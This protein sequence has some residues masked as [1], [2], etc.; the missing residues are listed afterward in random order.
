MDC[1]ATQ[2]YSIVS[3]LHLDNGLHRH[4]VL[5]THH[6]PCPLSTW[7]MD[8]TVTQYY[9]LTTVH[10]LSSTWTMDITVTQCY[11]PVSSRP[12]GQWIL[13]SHSVT[14]LCPLVHLDNGYY[15][16]TVLL[17]CV[18]SST[19]TMDI[20]VTQCYSP[21]SSRPPGQ[22]ISPS[23][24]T[25]YSPQFISSRPPGQWI[26]PSHSVTHLC[27]PVHLDNGYHRHTV[28]YTHHSSFPLVHLDNG[29]HR[30]TVPYTHH[31]SFPL[32][33]LDNGYHRHTVLYTHY[34]S[35]P[36]VHLDN[37]YHRH[38]QQTH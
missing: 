22:W 37:G 34:S 9:I 19:W 16:H 12:P 1:P 7:T 17:T 6:S 31:S 4:T 30:H 10:F 28:L 5:Y 32:V 15:R 14:H 33:H 11:S 36:L 27:P 2:Y 8:C 13:P 20:T 29:Y 23:H 18:L 26:S 21:V 3:S 25:I 35:F 24:S 38:T